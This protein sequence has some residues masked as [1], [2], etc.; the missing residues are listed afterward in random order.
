MSNSINNRY[1]LAAFSK[2]EIVS[3]FRQEADILARKIN[4]II[5]DDGTIYDIEQNTQHPT[6]IDWCDNA[7]SK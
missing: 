1:H 5:N 3:K 2:S 6:L 4:I 7:I